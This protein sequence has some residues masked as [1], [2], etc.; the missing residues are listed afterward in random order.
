MKMC[1]WFLFCFLRLQLTVCRKNTGGQ[2]LH[3]IE[4]WQWLPMHLNLLLEVYVFQYLEK[5]NEHQG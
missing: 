5:Y 2:Y 4:H 1:S 3:V